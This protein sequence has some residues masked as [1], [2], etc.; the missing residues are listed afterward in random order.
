MG[1]SNGSGVLRDI[2]L[3]V[4]NE[5]VLRRLRMS[6]DEC[7]R[8]RELKELFRATVERGRRII[9]P[10]AVCKTL[11][12][13]GGAHSV[14]RFRGTEFHIRSGGVAALLN[15]CS[16]ATLMAATIGPELSS[17]MD[18]L[19]AEKKM[20]E[21]MIMDAFG[22]EA[23]EEAVNSLCRLLRES[24]VGREFVPTGR[25]S[26]G[27][28]DWDLS[29]QREVLDELGAAQ[30]GISLSSS[31]ILIPEKSITAIMGWRPK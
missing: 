3:G 1:L 6:A 30:I 7:Q 28:G 27:Y 23:V 19:M 31:S 20:T 26:P 29:A 18:G 25:F 21:A 13:S 12:L 22:S 4:G 15:G 5:A 24:G 10:A 2:S 17:V 16:S 9:A 14:V 8:S 11:E